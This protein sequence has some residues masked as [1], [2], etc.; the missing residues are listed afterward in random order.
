MSEQTP[1][2]PDLDDFLAGEAPAPEAP[3]VSDPEPTT[4]VAVE[5]EPEPVIEETIDELTEELQVAAAKVKET[6]DAFEQAKIEYQMIAARVARKQREECP[7]HVQNEAVRQAQLREGEQ[8]ARALENLAN[9][10][11]DPAAVN[12]L[13]RGASVPAAP[14]KP[15]PALFPVK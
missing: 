6:Q 4:D 1:Q 2:T 11:F 10:G 5:P 14:R 3:I 8:R 13:A 7:L 15:H 12:I 9:L